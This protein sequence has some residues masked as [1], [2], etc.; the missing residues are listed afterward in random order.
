MSIRC[1]CNQNDL[2]VYQSASVHCFMYSCQSIEKIS[3]STYPTSQSFC[4][5]LIGM[6]DKFLNFIVIQIHQST[7][8]NISFCQSQDLF[9]CSFH[10]HSSLI[11][12]IDPYRLTCNKIVSIV[13]TNRIVFRC[14]LHSHPFI[15]MCKWPFTFTMK[16][17]SNMRQIHLE[18]N[19]R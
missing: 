10:I 17:F 1:K 18:Y 4:C 13:S 15:F 2:V 5:H 3:S 11:L 16:L 6:N 14:T 19:E 7:M 9:N 8:M 12:N